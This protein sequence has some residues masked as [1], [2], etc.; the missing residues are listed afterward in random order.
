MSIVS[1]R[2]RITMQQETHLE[3]VLDD[4]EELDVDIFIAIQ[5]SKDPQRV[6]RLEALRAELLKELKEVTFENIDKIEESHQVYKR[7]LKE[8][9]QP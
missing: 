6:A 7:L 1:P 9:K 3:V 4:M 2:K 8:F 5:H